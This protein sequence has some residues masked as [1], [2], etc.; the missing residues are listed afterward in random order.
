MSD[1]AANT[2]ALPASKSNNKTLTILA[3]V[4][5]VAALGFAMYRV[6][7][8]LL[9][10]AALEQEV[11]ILTQQAQQQTMQNGK[12]Q[13]LFEQS[14]QSLTEMQGQLAF[15][16]HTLNQIPGARLDD[17][18]L[19]ET[20]YL[21]RL[22]NQRVYLQHEFKGAQGLFDAANQVLASLDDPSFALVREQIAKEMLLLGQHSELDRAGIYSQLQAIKGLIHDAIQPPQTFIQ[23]T[24]DAVEGTADNTDVSLWQQI[25]SLVSVRYRDDA[26]NA[27]LTNSQYQL[28]EHNINLM[29]EQAQWA[30]L[31]ADNAIYHSSLQNAENWIGENLRHSNANTLLNKIRELNK[32]DIQQ[33]TPDVNT[34]LR[35]LRQI[36]QDRTYAPSPIKPVEKT[37]KEAA[38]AQKEQS[39]EPAEQ[40]HPK[41]PTLKDAP[42][43]DSAKQEQA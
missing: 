7:S 18:K 9:K 29:L 5:I 31:K 27:P 28:L 10:Q 39:S 15:M 1:Q 6:E 26:F 30:L 35:M 17:W 19:A 40:A 16:Q 21:L 4:V 22:A 14:E 23:E 8:L 13:T 20:E 42:Q 36:I 12:Q 2:K 11:A 3:S 37:E 24:P 43:L 25:L 34:S 38:P 33:T 41:A 32:I